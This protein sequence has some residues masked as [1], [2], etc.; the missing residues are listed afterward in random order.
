MKGTKASIDLRMVFLLKG[1][2]HYAY[3]LYHTPCL[4]SNSGDGKSKGNTAGFSRL[5]EHDKL[6]TLWYTLVN[7]LMVE[8]G[9]TKI[10]L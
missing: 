8:S 5:I 1:I 7:L 2:V 4:I 10:H 9:V 3:E 6:A